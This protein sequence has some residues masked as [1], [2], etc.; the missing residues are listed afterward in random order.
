[1]K[2]MK[3]IKILLVGLL[4]I[5]TSCNNSK[6]QEE[7]IKEDILKKLP[8]LNGVMSFV[9]FEKLPRTSIGKIKRR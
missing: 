5:M 1:M 9:Y 2:M 7:K 4:I 6:K 3:T 8:F